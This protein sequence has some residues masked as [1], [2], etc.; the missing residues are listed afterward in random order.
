MMAKYRKKPVVIDA[1]QTPLE[2]IAPSK[3]L[4]DIVRENDWEANNA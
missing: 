1:W 2:G 4:S 3:E